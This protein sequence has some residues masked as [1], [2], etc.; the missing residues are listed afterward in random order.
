MAKVKITLMNGQLKGAIE[1]L[2]DISANRIS[3]QRAWEISEVKQAFADKYKRV[4]ETQDNLVK[5]YKDE[6]K[7]GISPGDTNWD[8]FAAA[9][10]EMATIEVTVELEPLDKDFVLSLDKVA[11]DSIGTLRF[12]GV[13][14]AKD[15]K[16]KAKAGK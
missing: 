12:L 2:A 1:A 16:P 7:N 11:A 14:V 8:A 10:D 6:D 3:G 9:Y 15:Q 13:I 4:A 5:S